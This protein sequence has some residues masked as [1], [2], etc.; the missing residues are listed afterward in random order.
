MRRPALKLLFF[1]G[2]AAVAAGP[3]GAK[4]FLSADE[5]LHLAF[6]GCSVERRTVFLTPEQRAG[7]QTLAKGEVKSALINPYHAT[8]DGKDGGTAYFDGHVVRTL[9][10]TL[11]VVIDPQ[12]KVARVEVLAFAEPEDYLPPGRWYGQFLGQG[13]SDDLALGHHIRSVTGASLTARATTDAVR[14]VLAIHQVLR[15][16]GTAKP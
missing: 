14:R 11:M 12:G 5:A 2:L 16:T 15:G 10:E 4:V 1:A 3:V 8:C 7:I 13:L 6:K 9:S